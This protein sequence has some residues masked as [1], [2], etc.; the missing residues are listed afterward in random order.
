MLTQASRLSNREMRAAYAEPIHPASL[1]TFSVKLNT[2][3]PVPFI[4]H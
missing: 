1:N 2:E 4:V 3:N